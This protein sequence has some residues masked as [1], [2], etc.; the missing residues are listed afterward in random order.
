MR[1]P[2]D[3]A[4]RRRAVPRISARSSSVKSRLR[5][6]SGSPRR[7]CPRRPVPSA[8]S[9]NGGLVAHRIRRTVFRPL[10]QQAPGLHSSATSG[11]KVARHCSAASTA[12]ACRRSCRMRSE[13]VW[14]VCTGRMRRTPSSTAFSTMKSVRAFLIGAK[15]SQR[16]GGKVCGLVSTSHTAMAPRLPASAR[17]RRH[18]PS[19]PLKSRITAHPPQPHHPDKV[20]RLIVRQPHGLP[21]A[22]RLVYTKPDLRLHESKPMSDRRKCQR[23]L[24]TR[25]ARFGQVADAPNGN[26]VDRSP[27]PSTRPYPWLFA[28]ADR[29]IGTWLLLIPCWWAL[30]SAARSGGA[31]AV[32]LWLAVSCALARS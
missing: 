18:S 13:L 19:R 20:V 15:T 2:S 1:G 4:A 25:N 32:D 14:R 12:W 6:R 27:P 26:W 8:G 24:R 7:P 22:K 11:T 28:R 9:A 3:D 23:P 29:P 31:A 5:G 10:A 17:R 16:S 30:A 21:L